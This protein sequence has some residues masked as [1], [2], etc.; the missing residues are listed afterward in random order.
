MVSIVALGCAAWNQANDRA[1]RLE[2]G[3]GDGEGWGDDA[4]R[5]TC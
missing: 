4:Q 5:G 2:D 1:R 3:K